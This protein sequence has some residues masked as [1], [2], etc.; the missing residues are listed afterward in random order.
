[1]REKLTIFYDGECPLCCMEMDK[2]RAR[3]N[4]NL[5]RLINIHSRDFERFEQVT[6]AEAM[7]VLHGVYQGQILKALDVTH[8][9]WQLVGLGFWVAPLLW[10]IIKPVSHRIYLQVAKHRQTISSFLHRRFGLGQA[11]CDGGV[12]YAKERNTNH[13]R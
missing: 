9:A 13:R 1:M 12:C 10:P 4:N 7:A 6:K 8:R 11:H 3:D 2:L 5:I